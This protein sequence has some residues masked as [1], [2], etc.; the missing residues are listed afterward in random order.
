MAYTDLVGRTDTDATVPKVVA[1]QLITAMTRESVALQLGV[2]VPTSTKDSKVPVLSAAPEAGWVVGDSGLKNVSKASF[3]PQSLTAEELAVIVPCPD[4]VLEDSEYPIWDVLNPLLARAMAR[5]L[6][7]AVCFGVDAPASFSASLYED[8]LA[9]GNSV[10]ANA[11]DPAKAVLLAAEQVGVDGYSPTGVVVRNGWQYG[12]AAANSQ[13][14]VAN[15]A[16]AASAFPLLLAGLGIR[17]E[18]AFWDAAVADAIVADWSKVLIG[19]RRDFTIEIFH[20]GVLQDETGTIVANLIQQDLSAVRCTMRCGYLLGKPVTD[21]D[22]IT[23]SPAAVV[24]PV[25]AQS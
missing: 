22:S 2:R 11:A 23:P 15:P 20:E 25:G 6:D 16:G 8:A 12:A 13:A 19:I 7:A 4:S 5:K 3:A 10:V 21:T 9:A 17:T 24:Y 18:P 14:L 1:D